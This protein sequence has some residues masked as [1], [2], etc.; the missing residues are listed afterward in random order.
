M[1]TKHTQLLHSIKV[2]LVLEKVVV[3]SNLL[4]SALYS[5]VLAANEEAEGGQF[6]IGGVDS[7]HNLPRRYSSAY[8]GVG[9][10]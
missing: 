7:A 9:H 2:L 5:K 3:E 4:D 10:K 1:A 8:T 6:L